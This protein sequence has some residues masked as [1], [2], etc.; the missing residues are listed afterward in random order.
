MCS[1]CKHILSAVAIPHTPMECNYRRGFSCAVCGQ[2][3][4]HSR[5][6]CPNV[7]A[8]AIRQGKKPRRRN[9][10]LEIRDVRQV[11]KEHSIEPGSDK[12]ENMKKIRDLANTM[13]PTRIPLF[14]A[15]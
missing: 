8:W 1:Y 11:L 6:D 13:K 10:Y 9:L 12:M 7:E 5:E 3:S 14:L 2:S 4:G 15:E